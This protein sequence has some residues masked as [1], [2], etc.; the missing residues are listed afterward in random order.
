MPSSDALMIQLSDRVRIS[1]WSQQT[2]RKA[3]G[4]PG[5]EAKAENQFCLETDKKTVKKGRSVLRHRR[6]QISLAGC[7]AAPALR[8]T[9]HHNI[10]LPV[11]LDAGPPCVGEDG[12]NE[13]Q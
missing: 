7:Q 13:T 12:E 10:T 2:K 9:E 8:G 5:S 11:P 3:R 4:E 1:P 6:S